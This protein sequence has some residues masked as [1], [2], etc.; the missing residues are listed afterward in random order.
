MLNPKNNIPLTPLFTSFLTYAGELLRLGKPMNNRRTDEPINRVSEGSFSLKALFDIRCP[1][2]ST[3]TDPVG[4]VRFTLY[5]QQFNNSTVQRS[6]TKASLRDT[7]CHEPLD[8]APHISRE[9]RSGYMF[10][11]LSIRQLKQTAIVS[12]SVYLPFDI[13]RRNPF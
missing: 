13:P 2:A 4:A 1:T 7:T 5:T 9:Y 8:Q 3:L 10:R 12:Y 11:K 6:H